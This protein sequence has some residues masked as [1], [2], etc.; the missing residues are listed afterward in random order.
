MNPIRNLLLSVVVLLLILHVPVFA[1]STGIT[2]RTLNSQGGCGPGGCHNTVASTQTQLSILEAV[3]GELH[4]DAGQTLTLTL[5]VAHS[6]RPAAGVN[7]AVK[8]MLQ[9]GVDIGTLERIPGAGLH[10]QGPELTHDGPKALTNGAV[11]F[12]FKWKA[13]S[14]AGEYYLHAVGNAV[15]LNGNRDANDIWN[16]LTPIKIIVNPPN[17]VYEATVISKASVRPLPAHDEAIVTANTIAGE[18]VLIQ[19][20]DIGGRVV[21]RESLISNSNL[22]VYSWNGL[23]DSG[24]PAESGVYF[25]TFLCKNSASSGTIVWASHN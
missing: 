4:V 19:I 25:V 2:M 8:S 6:Q 7:I 3:A 23:S 20:T 16:W 1:T 17:S 9:S 15:N 18:I 14:Q 11:E 12:A 5:K 22:M 13:P 21:K 10:L 24:L